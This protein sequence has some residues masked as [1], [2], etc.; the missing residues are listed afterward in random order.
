MSPPGTASEVSAEPLIKGCELLKTGILLDCGPVLG[1]RFVI[2]GVG[3]G[4]N[5]CPQGND[6]AGCKRQNAARGCRICLAPSSATGD[7][8]ASF[9]RRH[10]AMMEEVREHAATRTTQSEKNKVL[11]QYG[12]KETPS[13]YQSLPVDIWEI[14]PHDPFHLWVIGLLSLFLSLFAQSL[15]ASALAELNWLLFHAKPWFWT[16]SMP[17]FKLTTGQGTT[18]RNLK[19]RGEDLRKQIQIL[20]LLL[21]GWLT[22]AKFAQRTWGKELLRKHNSEQNVKEAIISVR[23]YDTCTHAHMH[24]CTHAHMHT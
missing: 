2:G 20:P 19:G 5:D 13:I 22:M 9:Q 17:L 24:T 15:C 4:Q 14:L 16:G 23:A 21:P 12:L 8:D 10:T 6:D 3:L 18:R 7:C 1:D 11:T